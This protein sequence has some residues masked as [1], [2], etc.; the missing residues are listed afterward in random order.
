M[1]SKSRVK[2]IQS[3][4]HK[5]FRDEEGCFVVEGPKII[6]ELLSGIPNNIVSLYAVASWLQANQPLLQQLDP[7][8]VYRVEEPDLKRISSLKTPNQVLA[9][10]KKRKP[11]VGSSSKASLILDRIQDPGNFGTIIRTAD[12]FGISSVIC[13][14]D[15]ADLYNPK[16]IQATMGSMLRVEVTY[17]SLVGWMKENDGIPVFAAT[18]H[19]KSLYEFP[20]MTG[21]ALLIGNESRG[22]DPEL[23]SLCQDEI[24]IPRIGT[25]ESLNAAVATGILLSHLIKP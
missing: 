18:L 22:I 6:T 1:L 5:K 11:E 23:L 10:V 9:V 4:Y 8:F 15:C 25:A 13:S 17:T 21:G 7:S 20:A 19:G 16:V 3:L 2:Y 24:T 12:W 14:A